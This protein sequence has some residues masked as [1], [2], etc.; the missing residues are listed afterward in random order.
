MK[1]KKKKKKK[2]KKK[3]ESLILIL[4]YTLILSGRGEESLSLYMQ[5][6]CNVSY[7]KWKLLDAG[8]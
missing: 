8:R 1:T 7:D 6:E 4:P 5:S 2:K 3:F